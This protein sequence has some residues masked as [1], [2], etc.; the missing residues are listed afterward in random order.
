MLWVGRTFKGH[1]MQSHPSSAAP[2]PFPEVHRDPR[3]KKGIFLL[4][5]SSSFPA[6]PAAAP[7]VAEPEAERG[8]SPRFPLGL[9][10][11]GPGSA[12]GL[13]KLDTRAALSQPQPGSGASGTTHTHGFLL[14]SPC[15][16][17]GDVRK[18][19]IPLL[20]KI[21]HFVFCSNPCTIPQNHGIR[22]G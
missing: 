9:S 13:S 17:A 1:L 5:R 12:R 22:L 18:K 21:P 14:L 4:S 11:P 15:E 7:G 19:R 8:R 16:T 3:G 6:A 20:K 10:A 2:S